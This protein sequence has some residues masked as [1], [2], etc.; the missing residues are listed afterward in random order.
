MYKR[1]EYWNE[2]YFK[3]WKKRVEESNESSYS[4]NSSKI[5]KGDA[6]VAGDGILEELIKKAEIKDG[7]ILEIGCGWG[8][9]FDIY[10][11]LGLSIYA[12]DISKKMVEEAKKNRTYQ[13]VEIKEAEIENI[14]YKENFFDFVSCFATF[15]ATYQDKA[16]SEMMRVLKKKGKILLTGKNKSYH[17]DDKLAIDAEKGAR[18]KGHPNYFTDL[19]YLKEQIK[20]KGH[21]ISYEMY[22]PR[23]GDFA[24]FNFTEIMPN[25]FYEY[26][27][28]IQ[29]LTDKYNFDKFYNGYSDVA[30]K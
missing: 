9:L 2:N 29:K 17:K 28:V 19:K 21:S 7:K 8:R 11:N 12:I 26:Y 5:I 18:N 10:S 13:V 22:F 23:R 4:E 15:D 6:K 3:Y 30:K 20:S 27:I 24:K 25:K 16:L 1:K 14:P